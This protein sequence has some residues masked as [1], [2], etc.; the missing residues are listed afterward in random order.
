MSAPKRTNAPPP[1]SAAD[2]GRNEWL[3]AFHENVSQDRTARRAWDTLARADLEA[4]ALRVLWTFALPPADHVKKAHRAV[5]RI[6]SGTKVLIRADKVAKGRL[7]GG[8]PRAGLFLQRALQAYNDLLRSEMPFADEG[9]RVGDWALSRVAAGKGVPDLPSSRKAFVSL[10]PRGAVSDR[11]FWLFVLICYAE[12]AGVHLGLERLA[13]LARCAV[14]DYE[15]DPRTLARFLASLR[16]SYKA[17]F[18]RDLSS[19][20]APSLLPPQN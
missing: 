1:I 10:G 19:I 8:D 4:A 5:R 16:A 13:A 15:L 3:A 17:K 9:V 18:Q 11:K 6:T 20:P 2:D 12:N 14:P 7:K